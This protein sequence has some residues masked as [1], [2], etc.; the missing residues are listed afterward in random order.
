[1]TKQNKPETLEAQALHIRGALEDAW[2]GLVVARGKVIGAAEGD[3]IVC[4][5][6]YLSEDVDMEDDADA[7]G[8]CETAVKDSI[9]LNDDMEKALKVFNCRRRDME[10][11]IKNY[12]AFVQKRNA[13]IEKMPAVDL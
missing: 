11:A 5:S 12:H 1:M 7:C 13:A 10:K 3:H 6:N 8:A 2:D 4:D 9:R